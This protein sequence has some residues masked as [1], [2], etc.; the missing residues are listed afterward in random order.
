MVQPQGRN[1]V[2][3]K[4]GVED[5]AGTFTAERQCSGGHLVEDRPKREQVSTC[6]QLLGPHLLRRHVSY[7]THRR[8]GTRQVWLRRTGFS[9]VG[10]WLRPGCGHLCQPEIQNL[11]WPRSVTKMLAGFM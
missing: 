11:A 3:F 1:R 8:S 9:S 7:R 6:I 5:Y 10:I 4:N 2:V